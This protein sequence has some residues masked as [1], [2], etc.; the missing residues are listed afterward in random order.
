M[1]MLLKH[2]PVIGPSKVG[3]QLEGSKAF[4]KAFMMRQIFQRL[5]TKNLHKQI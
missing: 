2:I 5:L 3:A 1:M 4:S